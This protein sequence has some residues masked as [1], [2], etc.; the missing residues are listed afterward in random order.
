MNDTFW[1][2][3]D[4]YHYA[5]PKYIIVDIINSC[6]GVPFKVDG[7]PNQYAFKQVNK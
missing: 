6:T 4:W 5:V 7:E 2:R 1:F 3:Q